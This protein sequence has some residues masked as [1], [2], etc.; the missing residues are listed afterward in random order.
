MR[1][2]VFAAIALGLGIQGCARHV[3]LDPAKASQL[4]HSAWTVKSEPGQT[5]PDSD[6]REQPEIAPTP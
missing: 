2:L 6:Q 3:T 5:K 1:A 4:N